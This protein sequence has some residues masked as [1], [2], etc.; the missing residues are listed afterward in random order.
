MRRLFILIAICLCWNY[1]ARA[2]SAEAQQLLLNWEKLNQLKEIL[3]N[4]Y[5]GY[6][7][8]DT[9]YRTI[10]DLVEGNFTIHD[11]FIQGLM[12]VNPAVRNYK[13]VPY[14]I[15]YQQF[16]LS[17]YKRAFNR[18]KQDP[19]FTPD[20]LEYLAGVYEHLFNASLENIEELLM[21]I[22]A[23]KLSMSDD[24]RLGAIDRIFLDMEDKLTFLRSFNNSTSMLAIQRAKS[25]NDVQTMEKLYGIY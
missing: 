24:E 12:A 15:E 4:M 23:S 5:K 10:R 21:I 3:D 20:E 22:T 17:E 1:S 8:L 14:I 16:L 18:F 13:R 19:N 25:R 2:Q 7:I 6:K 11:V 9:G